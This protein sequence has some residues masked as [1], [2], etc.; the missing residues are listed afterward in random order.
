MVE[1]VEDQ[2]NKEEVDQ[3]HVE[4]LAIHPVQARHQYSEGGRVDGRVE[5]VQVVEG[6]LTHLHTLR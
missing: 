3:Q 2:E 5:G 6:V 1:G 4:A